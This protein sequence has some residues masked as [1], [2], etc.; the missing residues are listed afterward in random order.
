[1]HQLYAT[2]LTPKQWSV[3]E[4]LIPPPKSTGRPRTVNLIQVMQAILYVLAV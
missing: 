4:P 2:E 1:M 3:L